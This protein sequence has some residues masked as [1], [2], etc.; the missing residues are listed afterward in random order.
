[1]RELTD[2]ELLVDLAP[3]HTAH[4]KRA[5]ILRHGLVVCSFSSV[6][7]YFKD[8]LAEICNIFADVGFPFSSFSDELQSFLIVDGIIG[9]GNRVGFLPNSD[10]LVFAD[11]NLRV[12][13]NFDSQHPTFTA[14][15]FSPRGSNIGQGDVATALKAFSIE[16]PWN[17]LSSYASVVGGG[18]P[19]LRNDFENMSRTRNSSA[20]NPS[21]NVPTYDVQQHIENATILSVCFDLVMAKI[22]KAIRSASDFNDYVSKVA[23]SE[24]RIRYIDKRLDGAWSE[25]NDPTGRC[26]KKH[27]DEAVGVV[28]ARQRPTVDVVVVRD[29]Q[30]LPLSARN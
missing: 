30:S 7:T 22:V 6:E 29:L 20:H 11:Q 10:K 14:F 5:S 21:S 4:N 12:L 23:G 26:L 25:R 17:I 2:H 27:D 28:S 15:G 8:R 18:T 3:N 1:M 9:L 16:G 24:P 13:S 19:N